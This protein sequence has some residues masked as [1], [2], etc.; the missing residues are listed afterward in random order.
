MKKCDNKIR[1]SLKNSKI[2]H[3]SYSNYESCPFYLHH[4]SV[5]HGIDSVSSTGKNSA[6]PHTSIILAAH[7]TNKILTI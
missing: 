1:T 5:G 7:I 3:G 6:F 2:Q 4:K